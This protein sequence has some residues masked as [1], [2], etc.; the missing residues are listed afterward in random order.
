MD[1]AE[2]RARL[3]GLYAITPDAADG[4]ALLAPV[5]AAIDGGARLVQYRA[6][7]ID[8]RDRLAAAAALLALCR[9]RGVPLVVNDDVE[10]AL[11]LG[12][13]GVH[14][15]RDDGD[16]RAARER[17]PGAIIGVSC[18]D[19][20][21]RAVAAERAGADYVGIGSVFASTTKPL[22]AKA[23]LAALAQ[24]RR[25]TRLPIAAI[26]GITASNAAD[27]VRAGADMLAVISALFGAP[28]VAAAARALSR[29]FDPETDDHVR[30]QPAAL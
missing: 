7:G 1:A 17:L 22:A 25:R 20:P 16:P 13:D 5:A 30:T 4:A 8:R 12:A 21:E 24:A 19:D 3:R 6:K 27:A 23:G 28:D 10:L 11:A 14:L 2:R 15:G 9:G 26:G 18:Y 29:P